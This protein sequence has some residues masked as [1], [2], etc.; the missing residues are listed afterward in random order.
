[1]N[2]QLIE[3]SENHHMAHSHIR[4]PSIGLTLST[5]IAA[6]NPFLIHIVLKHLSPANIQGIRLSLAGFDASNFQLS[7]Y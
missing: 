7:P 6:N 2:H 4:C 3:F 5:A 1:M